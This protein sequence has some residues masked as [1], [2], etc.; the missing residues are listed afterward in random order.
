LKLQEI[1]HAEA[2]LALDILHKDNKH[3]IT[4]IE[5]VQK[6]HTEIIISAS[7]TRAMGKLV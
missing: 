3:I 5:R 7:T 4:M 2:A 6:N 1:L